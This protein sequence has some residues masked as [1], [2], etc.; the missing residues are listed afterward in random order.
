[1]RNS[2]IA[3]GAGCANLS[4]VDKTYIMPPRLSQ[5]LFSLLRGTRMAFSPCTLRI[6][7]G[8]IIQE[9]RWRG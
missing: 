6:P 9:I 4:T 7:T 3:I 5:V 8:R 2:T 1:M